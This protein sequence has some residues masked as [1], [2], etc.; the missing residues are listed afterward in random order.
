M[1]NNA[2]KKEQ[3]LKHNEYRAYK[4]KCAEELAQDKV[5][6]PEKYKPT[7]AQRRAKRK[8]MAFA[9]MAMSISSNGFD[10]RLLK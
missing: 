8:A 5:D 2:Y 3:A 10:N 4:N 9:S 1:G 7:R 6:N